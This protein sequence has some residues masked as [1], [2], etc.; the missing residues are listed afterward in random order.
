MHKVCIYAVLGKL[1]GKYS[2]L[3]CQL[4]YI[5]ISFTTLKL[6]LREMQQAE[7]QQHDKSSL[8]ATKLFFNIYIY[9]WIFQL[10]A[11]RK[12]VV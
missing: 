1:L 8:T 12:S 11:G 4:L 3:S 2:E 7:L 5:K 9:I 6:P 10:I